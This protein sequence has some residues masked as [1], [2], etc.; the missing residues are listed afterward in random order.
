[1]TTERSYRR[2]RSALG[3]LLV[4]LGAAP[5][6]AAEGT[7]SVSIR[8][9]DALAADAHASI[10]VLVGLAAA[11]AD[12]PLT[13]TPRVEGTSLELVRGR[14]L[15]ADAKQVDATHLRFDVPVVARS[16]G[17]AILRVELL[18]YTCDPECRSVTVQDSR[19]L[20]VR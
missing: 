11:S 10:P 17:T 3:L 13:L 20:Q 8:G 14:F 18:T 9:P 12:W 6:S 19:V 4:T 2:R 16:Q 5:L 7:P 1:M 15:R